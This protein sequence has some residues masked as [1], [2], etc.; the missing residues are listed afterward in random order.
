MKTNSL[1]TGSITEKYL[2]ETISKLFQQQQL[3][4]KEKLIFGGNKQ[5]DIINLKILEVHEGS[6]ITQGLTLADY[7]K[8]KQI[9]FRTRHNRRKVKVT[10]ALITP[11]VSIFYVDKDTR[12]W[13]YTKGCTLLCIDNDP[14]RDKISLIHKRAIPF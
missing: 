6:I 14:L 5:I 12:K 1:I 8:P 7:L 3:S 10:D 4:L 13:P 9:V 2:E 11:E